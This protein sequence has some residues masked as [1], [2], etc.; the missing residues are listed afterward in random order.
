MTEFQ[1]MILSLLYRFHD[2]TQILNSLSRPQDFL[3]IDGGVTDRETNDEGDDEL[4]EQLSTTLYTFI[5]WFNMETTFLKNQSNLF[6]KMLLET[7]QQQI[8]E[9]PDYPVSFEMINYSLSLLENET[10]LFIE[11][12][13]SFE[14]DWENSGYSKPTYDVINLVAKHKEIYFEFRKL[15][16]VSL[17]TSQPFD[18]E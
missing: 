7:R 1:S 6:F 9:H 14:G 5:G 16:R 18:F 3:G 15:L 11:A 8:E 2:N 10:S 4:P 13:L 17:G 12:L